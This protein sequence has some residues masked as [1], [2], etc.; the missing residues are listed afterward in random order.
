MATF[1]VSIPEDIKKKIDEHP[2]IN[3]PE[4]LKQRFE[5]RLKELQAFEELRNVGRI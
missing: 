1:T 5:K 4:Y 2:E 3:W